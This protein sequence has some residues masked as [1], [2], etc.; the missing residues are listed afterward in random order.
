MSKRR[1]CVECGI[2]N[3]VGDDDVCGEC[4]QDEVDMEDDEEEDTEE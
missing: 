3:F 4:K 1:R 2:Y